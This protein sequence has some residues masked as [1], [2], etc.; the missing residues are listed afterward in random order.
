MRRL[1]YVACIIC[2]F[3]SGSFTYAQ[4]DVV[5]KIIEI[6]TTDNQTM[7]HLDVLANRFGGRLIGSNDYDNA[8]EWCA[9]QFKK[10]GMDVIMDESGELPVGFNRGYWSG[11]LIGE[12]G[13][14]LHFVTP[15]YTAGT[16]G[17]QK[18]H[19]L[20]EPKTRRQ[21]ENMKGKLKG[22]W[23]LITGNSRGSAIDYSEEGDILRD[24]V[25]I[26][27]AKINEENAQIRAENRRN[28]DNP[29]YKQKELKPLKDAP[30]LFY[31]EM[32]EAGILGIIQSGE[33]PLKALAD[34]K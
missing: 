34:R 13:M 6:G 15:S 29:D 31:K 5:K 27:N 2:L 8:A 18:G 23:V 26:N 32:K 28:R 25:L 30:A 11:R 20:M 16:K 17:V 1:F 7:D 19:V 12:N 14:D 3:F 22:A 24:S 21:L 9:A 10:W 33:V 4:D